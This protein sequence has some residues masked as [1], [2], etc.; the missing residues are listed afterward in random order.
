MTKGKTGK[1]EVRA[2]DSRGSYV[3]C[4]YLDPKTMKPADKK[5][6]LILKDQNGKVSEYFIIPLKDAK[7][8]LLLTA[9]SEEKERQVWNEAER[10]VE[11][12]WES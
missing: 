5:R 6:K 4:K 8:S 2:V 3:M 9:E 7:R 12:I 1:L 10:K 11:E